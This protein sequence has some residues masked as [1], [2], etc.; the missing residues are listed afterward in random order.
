MLIDEQ[1]L[2]FMKL[3]NM[4]HFLLFVILAFFEK[5]NAQDSLKINDFAPS[6]VLSSSKNTVQS[7]NFNGSKKI[8]YVRFWSSGVLK[9]KQDFYKV[10]RLFNQNSTAIYK[11]GESFDV[12]LVALQSDK[13]EWLKDIEKFQL[14]SLN[15]LIATKSFKD[16]F[17]SK[18]FLKD[19]PTSFIIDEDGRIVSIN[20]DL[21]TVKVF[22]ESKRNN[23]PFIALPNEIVGKITHGE[24]VKTALGNEKIYVTNSKQD[25]IQTVL[26][27]STG[28][29]RI[30]GIQNK[31]DLTL[32]MSKT[33]KVPSDDNVYLETESGNVVSDFSKTEQGYE[34]QLSEDDLK[35]L[36]VLKEKIKA[37]KNLVF[38]ESFFTAG[39]FKL[40]PLAKGKLDVIV[41]KLKQEPTKRIE[42][43][44]HTDCSGEAAANLSLSTKRATSIAN[45]IISKGVAKTRVKAIGKGEE[46]PVNECVDGVNCLPEE[47]VKNRRTEFKFYDTE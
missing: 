44:S 10:K 5:A 3:N 7:I 38:E 46:E 22:I 30:S 21:N 9:S 14:G 13:V 35:D 32:K 43:I 25:T 1:N 17:V 11:M 33:E 36:R 40:T 29:F 27:N 4:K 42:V 39:Q 12:V 20:P 6:L 45:Y 31:N 23:V 41:D 18:Y 47:L 28:N 15:N 37:V 34:Y 2:N 16:F 26:T 24:S 19:L 8:Y